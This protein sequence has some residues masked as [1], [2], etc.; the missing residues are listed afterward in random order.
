MRK[1]QNK[2]EQNVSLIPTRRSERIKRAS[3]AKVC[4]LLV[5][6]GQIDKDNCSPPRKIQRNDTSSYDCDRPD[7]RKAANL[8]NFT[9]S[10]VRFATQYI[11]NP[12]SGNSRS[13]V[14]VRSDNFSLEKNGEE[15]VVSLPRTDSGKYSKALIKENLQ[16]IFRKAAVLESLVITSD[17]NMK[18]KKTCLEALY[19]ENGKEYFL[20]CLRFLLHMICQDSVEPCARENCGKMT[21]IVS[22]LLN[23]EKSPDVFN[24]LIDFCNE[25]HNFNIPLVRACIC[26]FFKFLYTFSVMIDKIYTDKDS[27]LSLEHKNEFYEKLIGRELDASPLVRVEVLK[28]MEL[29]Q[30]QGFSYTGGQIV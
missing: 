23:K 21:C 8:K 6:H 15:S 14:L 22:L 10:D 30:N 17:I 2:K 16:D 20:F 29:L 7:K 5:Y 25:F 11:K 12:D 9:N 27:C 18:L 19:V 26:M 1:L 24:L 13:S 28:C 4:H 3:V